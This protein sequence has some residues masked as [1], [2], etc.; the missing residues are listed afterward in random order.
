ME[1][2]TFNTKLQHIPTK[3]I[4][5]EYCREVSDTISDDTLKNAFRFTRGITIIP[6]AKIMRI[7]IDNI[8]YV[9]DI[10]FL[11]HTV[12]FRTS[13]SVSLFLNPLP[14]PRSQI[15]IQEIIDNNV[16]HNPS[17][18]SLSKY[19]I[20]KGIEK[21]EMHRDIPLIMK[22]ESTL[23]NKFLL[24]LFFSMDLTLKRSII[25]CPF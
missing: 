12:S 24:S 8:A 6:I 17:A 16:Y 13:A 22:A 3:R 25:Y 1:L 2:I 4:I 14:N 18:V 19:F 20:Y 23:L 5:R 9:E 21:T 10:N 15:N 7:T 11:Q